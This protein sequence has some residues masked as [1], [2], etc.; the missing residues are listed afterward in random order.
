[1]IG[2]S[3]LDRAATVYDSL[4]DTGTLRETLREVA[5]PA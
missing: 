3:E 5:E 1:L 2:D 4:G